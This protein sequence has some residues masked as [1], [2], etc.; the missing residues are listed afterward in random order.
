MKKMTSN[1]IRQLWEDFFESKGHSTIESAPLVPK[2]DDSLLFVNAGITPLKKYFDGREVPKNKRL[3]SIQKCIRTTDIENVGLTKRHLTSFEMM[4][5]F[6]IGDYFKAEALEFAFELLTSPEYANIPKE[7]LFI[8]VYSED[9]EAYDKWVSLG[10]DESHIVRLEGNFWEIGEGPCGPDS[11][12]F[13]DRGAS[14]DVDG[15][16]FEKFKNDEEQERFLEIWNNVFSQFNA[17]S[18]VKRQDYKEL[19]SKNIDTGAGLERWCVIFQDVDSVFETDLFVPI[20]NHISKLADKKY[21][22]QAEFKIIA[23]HARTAVLALSDGA[24]F[25]NVSRGYVLRRLVRRAIRMGKKLGIDKPFMF[26]LVETVVAVMKDSYP[27][28]LDNQAI[29]KKQIYDEEV[30]FHRTLISGEKRLEQLI[31]VARKGDNTVSGHDVFKLY[32]TYGFPYELTLEYLEEAGLTTYSN[33]FYKYMELQKQQSRE[34]QTQVT[35]MM[36]QNE[37]LL[38]F[39]DES[40]F[41]YDSY[42]MNSNVIALFKEGKQ[43]DKLSGEGYII[44]DKT[45]FYAESGG[46]VADRGAMKK[47]GA[48]IKVC[49]VQKAPNNQHIHFVDVIE[50]EVAVGDA[51]DIKIMP[52]ERLKIKRNHSSVHLLQ[53]ALHEVLDLNIRQAGSYV[54]NER[55]RFDFNYTGKISDDIVLKIEENVNRRI[56][57]ASDVEIK[58]MTLEE[59]KQIGA[60]A[61]FEDKYSDNVRVIKMGDSIELCGGTHVN[62]TSEIKRLAIVNLESKGSNVYRIEAVCGGNVLYFV[63]EAIKPY[64][65][66]VSKQLNKAKEILSSAKEENFALK[67]NVDIETIEPD[68]YASI[69][70]NRNQHEYVQNEVKKLEK[71]YNELMLEK[72]TSDIS[73]YLEKKEWINEFEV[74]VA[75]AE[76]LDSKAFK[77][78]VDKVANQLENSFVFMANLN[79][80]GVNYIASSKSVIHAGLMMKKAMELAGGNGGGSATYATGGSK[81]LDTLDEVLLTVKEYIRDNIK[82]GE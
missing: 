23:D 75:K 8:S 7:K 79:D 73:S 3:S 74:V 11:E 51:V 82:D 66:E 9:D 43:V 47:D 45:C 19:P 29:I 52:D 63:S 38:N 16:A 17:Q 60:L 68:S 54:D 77:A 21:Q 67:F 42:E 76:N 41:D 81:N 22:Q 36:S 53:A 14:F 35:S 5:N 37:E 48:K 26:E 34:K 28:L 33:E 31:E 69:I 50:G 27:E 24:V 49:D 30:L 70:F 64:V 13:Y 25:E 59:A 10:I 62:N 2:N 71:E 56:A 4:G 39:K 58:H 40:S 65:E 15:T 20:M 1:E 12:I 61:L 6:S 18:G 80:S 57:D 32:D 72:T 78:I 46:Q 44:L 55:L